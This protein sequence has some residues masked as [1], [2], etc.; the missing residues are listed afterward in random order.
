MFFREKH[1]G[2]MSTKVIT[3]FK[4]QG[5][6]EWEVRVLVDSRLAGRFSS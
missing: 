3:Y 5:T 4:V 1:L 2:G 6:G